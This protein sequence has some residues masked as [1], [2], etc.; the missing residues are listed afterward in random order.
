ME[1]DHK[2]YIL[3]NYPGKSVQEIAAHLGIKERKVKKF[4]ERA[5]GKHLITPVKK[6]ER[7]RKKVNKKFVVLAILIIAMLGIAVYANA[8]NGEFLLDDDLL[9]SDNTFVKSFVHLKSLFKQDLGSGIGIQSNY[10]RPLQMLSYTIDYHFWKLDVRPYHITNIITHI[11]MALAVCWMV[12]VLFE[13]NTLALFAAMLFVVH[14]IHAESAT[15]ISGLGD[16]MVGLFT[17]LAFILYVKQLDTDN[18]W[19]VVLLFIVYVIALFAKENSLVLPALFV[20]YHI[21]FKKKMKAPVF[22]SLVIMTGVYF[23]FRMSLFKSGTSESMTIINILQRVPGF[24]ISMTEYVRVLLLPFGLYMGH[25]TQIFSMT[26]P[27]AVLGCFIVLFL[28]IYAIM[29]HRKNK[30]VFFG[31]F[32]FFIT[33]GPVSNLY[34]IAFFMADHYLY[35]PSIGI[36][37]IIAAM[38]DSLYKNEKYR[39]YSVAVLAALTGFYGF[40]GIKQNEYWSTARH[41]YERTL[42]YNPNSPRMYSNLA[43]ENIKIHNY[44]EAIRLYKKAIEINPEFVNAHYNLGAV[45]NQLGRYDE[46]IASCERAIQIDPMYTHAYN[47]IG[48]SHMNRGENDAALKYFSQAVSISPSNVIALCNLGVSYSNAGNNEEAIRVLE[49]AIEANPDYALAYANLGYVYSR[50]GRKEEAIALLK[51]TLSL[52]PGDANAVN[53]LGKI[54]Y[55]LGRKEEAAGAFRRT[56]EIDPGNLNAKNNLAIVEKELAQQPIGEAGKGQTNE[57]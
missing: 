10:Y 9:I 16:C 23:V 56:L 11:L 6:P 45:Y 53:N 1:F 40:L 38:I 47:I 55:E 13:N 28:L 42:E 21:A 27:K 4:I 54:Y 14:P 32:W 31:I 26:D 43:K 25:E 50:V 19:M 5:R 39:I 15:Y 44:D 8:I 46:A 22:I 49:K 36:F 24:F 20:V 18:I 33:L 35:I 17:V 57:K 52:N 29:V 7:V 3:K 51:K 41:F 2:K 34:P 37:L 30:L 12:V 48:A